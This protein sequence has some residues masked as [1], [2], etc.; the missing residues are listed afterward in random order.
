MKRFKY[1][2]LLILILI[3]IGIGIKFL[4]PK[5]KNTGLGIT[6][7]KNFNQYDSI[8]INKVKQERSAYEIR[9][10]RAITS[11]NY[12]TAPVWSPDGEKIAITNL[13]FKGIIIENINDRTQKRITDDEGAGFR[14]SWSP[15]SRAITYLSRKI[16]NG[17]AINIIKIVEIDNGRTFELTS[18]G[19]GASMP[20]FTQ[21]NEVIY[22][23]KGTLIKRNWSDGAIGNEEIIAEN[24]P[25][26]I[27]VPSPKDNVLVIEDDKGIKI[28]NI[29]GSNLKSVIINGLNEFAHMAEV[30]FSGNK[31]LF[32]NNVGS[33]T[34][35]FIYDIK[36]EKTKDLGKGYFGHWLADGRVMYCKIEDDGIRNIKSDIFIIKEDG[37]SEEKITHTEDKIEIQPMMSSDGKHITYL[38]EKSGKIKL[39]ELTAKKSN[40]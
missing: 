6:P 12:Y 10:I 8:N 20:T 23:Y 39:G 37:T 40:L 26:N 17:E 22:S 15:N 9:N 21:S 33:I 25:A 14:F 36:S 4:I 38:E 1:I 35:M 34:H 30:S 18:P 3:A 5:W 27:I 29:N 31:V 11:E 19:I 32:F 16:I 13:N 24:V 28:I 7:L 2:L